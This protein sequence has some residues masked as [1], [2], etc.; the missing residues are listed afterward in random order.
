[1]LFNSRYRN[2]LTT[3]RAVEP[4]GHVATKRRQPLKFV[5]GGVSVATIAALSLVFSVPKDALAQMS[6]RL[7]SVRASHT[8]SYVGRA[9]TYEAWQ[10]GVKRRYHFANEI[11]RG[12]DGES[13]WIVYPPNPNNGGKGYCLISDEAPD[14]FG[15]NGTSALQSISSLD[16]RYVKGLKVS[17]KKVQRDSTTESV[18]TAEGTWKDGGRRFKH[19][20]TCREPDLP[21]RIDYYS[22]DVKGAR[23]IGYTAI[24]YPKAIDPTVFEF[25]PPKDLPLLDHKKARAAILE[26]IA[27]KGETASA[28]GETIT[29]LGALQERQGDGVYLLYT[30]GATPHIDCT[31]SVVD[32]KGVKRNVSIYYEE[33]DRERPR[34]FGIPDKATQSAGKQK[35]S[36]LGFD[37]PIQ[38]RPLSWVNGTAVYAL[39]VR[40]GKMNSMQPTKLT[41][42][43][44]ICKKGKSRVVQFDSKYAKFQSEGEQVGSGEFR[45]E[46]IPVDFVGTIMRQLDPQRLNSWGSVPLRNLGR[47]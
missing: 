40:L 38:I 13:V 14:G 1:M 41:I 5:V 27:G 7:A 44:P 23:L 32:E 6:Q 43:L 16:A 21:Y 31:A 22:V 17:T 20:Y 19:V 10:D 46:T 35:V 8:R 9:I 11:D 3:L 47:Q 28:D 12:Y 4:E 37:R 26:G 34:N 42:N 45:V 25:N 36:R 24:D 15:Y 39:H 29:F 30:G 18:T 33:D 2:A